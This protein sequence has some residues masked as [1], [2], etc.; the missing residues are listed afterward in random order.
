M[1][2][3]PQGIDSVNGSS[4]NMGCN[5]SLVDSDGVMVCESRS[6]LVD[7]CSP[8]INTSTADWASQLVTVRKREGTL[9]NTFN[10]F[11]H[12]LL[13]FGFD[14]AV[15]LTGIEMDWFLCSDWGIGAP[16]VT[17]YFNEDYNLT[18][19]NIILTLPFVSADGNSL[20]SSCNSLSTVTF[21]GGSLM[22][23]YYR[24]IHILVTLSA[25]PSIEWVRVGEV[26]FIGID[27]QTCLQ[28]TPSSSPLHPPLTLSPPSLPLQS[29]SPTLG[30]LTN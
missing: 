30:K 29:L 21:S 24:T 25:H 19:T 22:G 5:S 26:R 10:E 16:S 3:V 4:V 14:A 12:V 20:Q 23:A 15:S 17:V 7:G 18:N 2:V 28:P 27:G 6:Y 13:T 8:D 9:V 1:Q 11:R